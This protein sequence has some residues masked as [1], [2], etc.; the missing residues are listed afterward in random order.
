MYSERAMEH[1]ERGAYVFASTLP[2]I[3]SLDERHGRTLTAR[4]VFICILTTAV[5]LVTIVVHPCLLVSRTYATKC[6]RRHIYPFL[7]GRTSRAAGKPNSVQ[8]LLYYTA[9][10]SKIG[11]HRDNYNVRHVRR[12]LLQGNLDARDGGTPMGSEE[13]S[14]LL[15]S[16]VIIYSMGNA[17]MAFKMSFPPPGQEFTATLKE[18]VT[19]MCM[20]A[21]GATLWTGQ[22]RL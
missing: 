19:R 18:H 5:S 9:F 7:G 16:D 4:T 14:Q 13:N 2:S 10:S 8:L 20:Y 17:E 12:M 22:N 11:R 6:I 21:C 3:R 1:L 15:H